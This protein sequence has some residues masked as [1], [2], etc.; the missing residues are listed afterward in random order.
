MEC[1]DKIFRVDNELPVNVPQNVE[2]KPPVSER[3]DTTL[4]IHPSIVK[5]YKSYP[6]LII[7]KDLLRR[8]IDP[9]LMLRKCKSPPEVYFKDPNDIKVEPNSDD[10]INAF[11]RK[12][13]GISIVK[14]AKT[15]NAS[16]ACAPGIGDKQVIRPPPVSSPHVAKS[17]PKRK[18]S[19]SVFTDPKRKKITQTATYDVAMTKVETVSKASEGIDVKLFSKSE[20]ETETDD[21]AG[22]NETSEAGKFL[23]FKQPSDEVRGHD[24]EQEMVKRQSSDEDG[25]YEPPKRTR[26]ERACKTTANMYLKKALQN[27]DDEE[28]AFSSS[29]ANDDVW[30]GSSDDSPSAQ[31]KRAMQGKFKKYSGAKRGRKKGSKK[32]STPLPSPTTTPLP[33]PTTSSTQISTF[34]TEHEDVEEVSPEETVVKQEVIPEMFFACHFCGHLNKL[35]ADLLDH[36]QICRMQNTEENALVDVEGDVE[37]LYRIC[38]EDRFVSL[39]FTKY[40]RKKTSVNSCVQTDRFENQMQYIEDN[41]V[42]LSDILSD[43]HFQKIRVLNGDITSDIRVNVTYLKKKPEVPSGAW[44]WSDSDVTHLAKKGNKSAAF[45]SPFVEANDLFGEEIT[46]PALRET[47]VAEPPIRVRTVSE[48]SSNVN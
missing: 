33:S 21:T 11:K 25:T 47:D 41:E 4:A 6:K 48:L 10:D 32:T 39:V 8:N 14:V 23:G 27:S 44:K 5:L 1:I 43:L 35:F 12:C 9:Q 28:A 40:E 42:V 7:G 17:T 20:T 19:A 22:A 46:I 2:S 3:V 18:K 30:V 37:P 15:A 34:K 36:L 13:P 26:S 45:S 16:A 29:S 24:S 31:F 38:E